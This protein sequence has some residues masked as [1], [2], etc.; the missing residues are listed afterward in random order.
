MLQL[1]MVIC[2]RT[3]FQSSSS[4]EICQFGKMQSPVS[5]PRFGA[6][7]KFFGEI[8]FNYYHSAVAG[9]SLTNNGYN[10]Q[11]KVEPWR[12]DTTLY[13]TDGGL[14][15][16]Y[17]LDSV[18]FHWGKGLNDG[19]EHVVE[20]TKFGGE[21]QFVHFSEN[22]SNYSE[23]SLHKDGL[24]VVSVFMIIT[25]DN[26]DNLLLT[27]LIDELF[28]LKTPNKSVKITSKFPLQIFL[29]ELRFRDRYFRISGSQRNMMSWSL[30]STILCFVMSSIC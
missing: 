11:L 29:P 8:S 3:R 15:G 23:A 20:T 14:E 1:V 7:K 4:S 28:N 30:L 9:M 24:A 5:L 21:V 6:V 16:R 22:Y 25:D 10:L 26:H 13:I 27:P 2:Y 18:D 12:E 19:S 17:I